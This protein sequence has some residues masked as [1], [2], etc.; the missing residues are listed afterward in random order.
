MKY[1]LIVG[2]G[3]RAIE[4]FIQP[5]IRMESAKKYSIYALCDTNEKRMEYVRSKIPYEVKT[6]TNLYEIKDISS[7][8]Y[9]IITTRDCYHAEIAKYLALQGVKVIC[10]KPLATSIEQCK[11]LLSIK[12]QLVNIKVAFN[13][14]Y[15]PINK[16][17]KEIFDSKELGKIKYVNYNWHIDKKHGA[18]Y[19]RRWH[20]N[21]K[22]SG[23][24]LVHKACHHFDLV[25]WWLKDYPLSVMAKE[26]LEVFGP[27]NGV[28]GA[29]K[30]RQCNLKCD[31]KMTEKQSQE[32]KRLY[33]DNEDCDKY[34]RDGCVYDS[35]VDI[36]DTMSVI[37][38]YAKGTCLNYSLIM[39]AEKFSWDMSV[40][41]TDGEMQIHFDNFSKKI[42]IN[43]FKN[44]EI[45]RIAIEKNNR[46]HEGADE[47]LRKRLFIDEEND[48]LDV[49][50]GVYSVVI[51]ILADISNRENRCINIE[52]Y[53]EE[54]E[55]KESEL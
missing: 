50:E 36:Y 31:F 17:I 29:T 44:E 19:F 24:M 3:N 54:Q 53:L 14:R 40:V 22:A 38:N 26:S 23:G 42:F 20:R 27:K 2:C 33:F 48:D 49:V 39:Y 47:N 4:M 18:E 28:R 52:E 46:K 13:S 30:C 16:A 5:I 35:E 21:K 15:M 8:D 37:V 9:C 25:N 12:N 11:D 55:C 45:K 1:V 34:F 51:G 41:G 43:I 6:Y 7:V 32:F 10:E